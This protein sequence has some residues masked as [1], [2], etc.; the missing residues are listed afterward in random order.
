MTEIKD[1]WVT[2]GGIRTHYSWAGD[3]GQTVLLLH[4][5]GP[6][7]SGEVGWRLAI[8]VLA[9]AGFRVFA[10]DQLTMGQTDAR[11]HAYPVNGHQSLVDHVDAFV[12]ALCLAPVHLAGNSQGAYV[13]LKFALDHPEKA[14]SV[15]LIGSA[16][17]AGALG[18][19]WPDRENNPGLLALKSYD[20]TRAGMVRFMES[21]V[22]DPSKIPAAVVDARHE[23][24]NR[25]GIAQ[26]RE[27]FEAYQVRMRQE[28]KLWKR[29]ALDG[30]VQDAGLDVQL[31]WGRQDRFAPLEMG[32]R[33][34]ELVPEWAYTVI[35]AG[36]QCQTDEPELVNQMLIDHFGGPQKGPAA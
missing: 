19:D 23:M 6:G 3:S 8:P 7:S 9:E 29:Y 4:G 1:G 12:D 16:T 35:D 28:P 13:G 20:Y 11:E 2:A 25:P 34:A 33:V 26:S 17:I 24:A 36:H 31:L 18:V 5:G 32:D 14:G 30:K 22:N 27:V 15:F 21:V 10:P